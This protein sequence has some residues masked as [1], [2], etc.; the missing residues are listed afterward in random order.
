MNIRKIVVK[1][2]CIVEFVA[3]LLITALVMGVRFGDSIHDRAEYLDNWE[4]GLIGLAWLF[5]ISL[6]VLFIYLTS[7][8]RAIPLR[9]L[10]QKAMI[11]IHVLNIA[12]WLILY[13]AL[14]KTEPC[15]A[16]EMESHYLAHQGEIHSLITYTKDCLRDSTAIRYEIRHDGDTML[17]A[18]NFGGHWSFYDDKD[19]VLL[20]TGITHA[21]FDTINAM[22]KKAGVT[23][24][25]I[26]RN[27]YSHQSRLIYRSYGSSNYHYVINHDLSQQVDTTGG[28]LG[29]LQN[30]IYNDSICFQSVGGLVW[31]N[32]PDLD[33]YLKTKA[34]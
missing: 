31:H 20:I 3:A 26:N 30:I 11:A 32:F 16:A 5:F 23:G 13:L 2:Y 18:D 19:S 9:T 8:V 25:D 33:Q 22:M 12:L 28:L 14:P 10:R 7:F 21:Q 24:I 29:S 1:V 15:T 6:P 34:H 27:G 17:S 4:M